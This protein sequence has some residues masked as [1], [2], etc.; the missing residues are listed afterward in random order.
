MVTGAD[1]KSVLLPGPTVTVANPLGSFPRTSPEPVTQ[2]KISRST[3]TLGMAMLVRLAEPL[4]MLFRQSEVVEANGNA[5]PR[6]FPAIVNVALSA[7]DM[8]LANPLEPNTGTLLFTA[9]WVCACTAV[10]L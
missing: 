6:K 1:R 10:A 4:P 9:S 7:L 5:T 2:K 3:G 8:V